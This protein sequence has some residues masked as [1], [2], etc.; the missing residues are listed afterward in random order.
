M[1]TALITG[2]TKGLGLEI[3]RELALQGFHV[4]L[5]GRNDNAGKQAEEQL[6]RERLE[7]QF[8]HMDIAHLPSIRSAF[9]TISAHIEKLSALVNNAGIQLDTG[10][11]VLHVS[12]DVIYE[13][14]HV[15]ALGALFVTQI[16]APLLASGSRVVNV[17]SGGG[18]ISS[19]MGGWA[20]MYCVSK[21]TLN[22]IT[23]QLARALLSKGVAVNSVSPGWVRTDMGGS[24][25]PRSLEQGAQT[26]VWLATEVPLEQTGFFWQDKAI[27][28]W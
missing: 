16:F 24:L 22:A 28:P 26:P 17:S 6:R 5:S 25:A 2:S 20:P 7:A 15:N 14:L 10:E 23:I 19:G 21:V 11:S 9:Q 4:W 3:A 13:T 12:P 1:K 27:I 18:Q 8:V